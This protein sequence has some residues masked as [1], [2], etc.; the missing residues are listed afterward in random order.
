[1]TVYQILAK[2]LEG[3]WATLIFFKEDLSIL[4]YSFWYEAFFLRKKFQDVL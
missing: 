2:L 3:P 1:M 4:L